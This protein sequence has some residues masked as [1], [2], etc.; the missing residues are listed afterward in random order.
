MGVDF[1]L[2]YSGKR[3][4]TNPSLPEIEARFAA[5]EYPRYLAALA[6]ASGL[7]EPWQALEGAFYYYFGNELHAVRS[8]EWKLRV[9]LP[10]R[11]EDIY[12]PFPDR[13]AMMPEA[14]YH[15]PTDPGEQK[16]LIP[17]NERMQKLQSPDRMQIIERL[18]ALLDQARADLGDSRRNIPPTNIRPLGMSELPEE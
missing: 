18:H 13:E 3:L 6:E 1:Y 11:H 8:G 14:L 9:S 15:L 5:T 17:R 2:Q 16:N 10:M 7:N 4:D 12:Y